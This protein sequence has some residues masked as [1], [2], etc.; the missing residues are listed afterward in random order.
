MRVQLKEIFSRRHQNIE[1]KQPE[2]KRVL[3]CFSFLTNS[4]LV[5]LNCFRS[6]SLKRTRVKLSF[7]LE[8]VL[9]FFFEFAFVFDVVH[10]RNKRLAYS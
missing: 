5:Q 3:A 8:I 4:D 10:E 7:L 1:H 9:A 6:F 2:K